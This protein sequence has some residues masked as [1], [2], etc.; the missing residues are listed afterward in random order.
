MQKLDI[1]YLQHICFEF[2][3]SVKN[4]IFNVTKNYQLTIKVLWQEKLVNYK[5][6]Y[7]HKHDICTKLK[8]RNCGFCS[9]GFSFKLPHVNQINKVMKF[10]NFYVKIN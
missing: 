8:S 7:L 4:M 5:F 6:L 10:W 1:F 3:D 2:W 9:Q